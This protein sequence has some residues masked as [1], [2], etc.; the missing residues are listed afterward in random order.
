MI[1]KNRLSKQKSLEVFDYG[2]KFDACGERGGAGGE[3][4]EIFYALKS[5][6]FKPFKIDSGKAGRENPP[7]LVLIAAMRRGRS[8][9]L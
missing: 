5:L 6:K 2:G 9:I 7:G 3:C 8:G 1:G 4:E